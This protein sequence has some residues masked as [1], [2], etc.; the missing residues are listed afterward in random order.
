MQELQFQIIVDPHVE[1]HVEGVVAFGDFEGDA[2]IYPELGGFYGDLI[3]GRPFPQVMVVRQLTPSLVVASTLFLH[4]ELVLEPATVGL[5]GSM[6]IVD[7]LGLAGL[8]HVDRDLARFFKL[9]GGQFPRGLSKDEQRKRL[10]RAVEWVRQYILS[11]E[12]PALPPGPKPPRILDTGTGAFVVAEAAKPLEDGWVE[13]FRQG[14]LRGVLFTPAVEGRRG[15]LV[16]RK[17]RYVGLDT[18]RG[19]EAFNEA[20]RAMG[21]L[22]GWRAEE[23]WLWGPDEGT[24]LLPTHIIEVVIRL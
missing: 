20:E 1:N 8:A 15:V 18:L 14:A 23:L 6:A 24:L 10:E 5:V 22:P 2:A 9:L 16:A 21:E 12:L 3:Q 11:G 4:R 7:R 19:A 13:L 17:S